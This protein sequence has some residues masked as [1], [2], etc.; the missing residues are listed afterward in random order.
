MKTLKI[1]Q[2]GFGT[3]GQGLLEIIQTKSKD[4]VETEGV[5]VRVVAISDFQKGSVADPDGID[6]GRALE[7]VKDGGSLDS[8][9]GG[10]HGW[11]AL[12]T[13]SECGADVM[14]EAT[15]TDL[16]TGEP[17]ISHVKA[18]LEKGMHVTTT[19]KGPVVLA[20]R[21]MMDLARKNGVQFLFEGAVMSGTP[22]LSFAMKN[23][24]GCTISKIEGILNGTTN[25]MLTEMEAGKDYDIALKQAQ[26]LGY[27]EAVPDAD[28]E[29]FDAAGK[30]VILANLLLGAAIGPKDV[31][32]TGITGLSIGQLEKAAKDGLRYKLIGSA[33]KTAT[34]IAASVKPI[35]LPL[36]DPLAGVGGATNALTF[37]T[38]LLGPVTVVGAGAGR[39]ET[40][41]AL[42]QDLLDIARSN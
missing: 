32:R 37:H 35:A 42:L 6:I 17:A 39:V 28:V 14:C 2:I 7:A 12:T 25:Y 1:A 15:F 22:T 3:V 36:A 34:G 41:F 8:Y 5:E 11:D 10:S 33:E 40:G 4:L 26:E 23:L 13:I 31:D 9:E 27:A 29:G 30:V 24:A 16:E 38:D 21:E 20:A 19:N 18:A